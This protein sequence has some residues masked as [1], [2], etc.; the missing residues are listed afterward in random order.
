[1]KKKITA[2]GI[3]PQGPY[4]PAVLVGDWVFVS[5]QL[6][7]TDRPADIKEQ[8]RKAL[9]N[10]ETLLKE[11]GLSMDNV[12]KVTLFVKEG[13]DF[14]SVNEVYGEFFREVYPARSFVFVSSLPRGALIEIE[15]I[16]RR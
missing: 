7:I 14:S 10:V 13:E 11:T 5:G 3:K 6:G 2:K 9:Q 8:T 15:A 16:A 1:M 12:V 4:S